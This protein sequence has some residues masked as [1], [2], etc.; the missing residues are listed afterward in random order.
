MQVDVIVHL[1]FTPFHHPLAYALHRLESEL[2]LPELV[3]GSMVPDLEIP[4][5][6]LV[7]G[8]QV[9]NR[10]VLHSVLGAATAGTL[11]ATAHHD[12]DLRTISKQAFS[13][14]QTESQTEM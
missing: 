9:P 7:F 13:I 10:M 3:V 12:L 8:T 4:I 14:R 5:I 11:L 2:S 1:P 6:F